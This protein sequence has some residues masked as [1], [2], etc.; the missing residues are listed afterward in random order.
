MQTDRFTVNA[1]VVGLIILGLSV[2]AGAVLLTLEDKVVSDALWG[3][4]GTAVGALGSLLARTSTNDE[5]TPV[6]VVN[7]PDAPVPVDDTPRPAARTRKR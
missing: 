5:S 6:H 4:A 7:Q 3:L 1:V 2:V